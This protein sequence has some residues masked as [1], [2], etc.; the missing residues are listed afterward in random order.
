MV[1]NIIENILS[2]GNEIIDNANLYSLVT[3]ANIHLQRLQSFV[4]NNDNDKE[5][6]NEKVSKLNFI[7]EQFK[8]LFMEK[9]ALQYSIHMTLCSFLIYTQSSN[10]YSALRKNA[11]LT[12][13]HP[14]T[15]QRLSSS[16]HIAIDKPNENEYFLRSLASKLNEKE[17]YVILQIDEIYIKQNIEYKNGSLSGFVHN[18]TSAAKIVIAFVIYSAFGSFKEI[19]LLIPVINVNGNELTSYTKEVCK[20]VTAYDFKIIAIITDNNRVNRVMFKELSSFD[21]NFTYDFSNTYK[22]FLS[23]DSVHIFKNIRNNWLCQKDAEKSFVFP[24]FYD[25]D[26]ILVAKFT[27]IRQSFRKECNQL[28]K[29]APKLNFKTV[30]P[31]TL[32]RQKVSLANNVFHESTL[33]AVNQ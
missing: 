26:K 28:I 33:A 18:D 7:I 8:L 31:S 15:L 24:S 17:K 13:R 12:L 14:R 6:D 11:I 5:N 25:R 9:H 29:L 27:D 4:S 2:Y 32:D 1:T 16:M 23:Y 10:C 3:A 21:N 20:L 19:V 22:T 30:F